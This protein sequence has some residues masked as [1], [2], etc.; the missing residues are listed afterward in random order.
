[1]AGGYSIYVS[2]NHPLRASGGKEIADFD[3]NTGVKVRNS[4]PAEWVRPT[5]K[6]YLGYSTSNLARFLGTVRKWAGFES[7]P[8]EVVRR[9]GESGLVSYDDYL[10]MRLELGTGQEA[11]IYTNE[12]TVSIVPNL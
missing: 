6:G 10:L 11:G 4:N 9:T 12:I 8:K 7:L 1:I 5:G 2:E 3:N